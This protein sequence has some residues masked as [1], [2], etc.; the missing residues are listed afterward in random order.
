VPAEEQAEKEGA[1]ACGLAVGMGF[2]FVRLFGVGLALRPSQ[3]LNVRR[4]MQ[5][6]S[7]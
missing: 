1:A 5:F 3:K 4:R 6:S 7:R 2:L